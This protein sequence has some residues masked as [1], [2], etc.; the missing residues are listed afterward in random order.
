LYYSTENIE[1]NTLVDLNADGNVDELFTLTDEILQESIFTLNNTT[2]SNQDSDDDLEATIFDALGNELASGLEVA[3]FQ[4][5]L[6]YQIYGLYAP[7]YPGFDESDYGPRNLNA[8]QNDNLAAAI[9]MSFQD[10]LGGTYTPTQPGDK[11]GLVLIPDGGAQ[12]ILS[13]VEFSIIPPPVQDLGISLIKQVINPPI[14]TD[15]E[16]NPLYNVGDPVTFA[17]TVSNTGGADLENITLI[18]DNAT[19]EPSDDIELK[20]DGTQVLVS[21]GENDVTDSLPDGWSV[22]FSGDNGDGILNESEEWQFQITKPTQFEDSLEKVCET[23][24]CEF[25]VFDSFSGSD[26]EVT[27]ILEEVL[28]DP[29]T[30]DIDESGVRVNVEVSDPDLIGD[31]RGVFFDVADNNVMAIMDIIGNDVESYLIAAD[32]V[33]RV[34]KD[35]LMRGGGTEPFDVGVQIGTQGMSTDDIQSTSFDVV[36]LSIEDLELQRF[37]IRLTSVGED[38]GSREDSSKIIGYAPECGTTCTQVQTNLAG[39]TGLSTIGEEPV[40]DGFSDDGALA[41]L[42]TNSQTIM[43]MG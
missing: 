8:T 5:L 35:V 43:V 16:G 38:G 37:G 36:G 20:W 28:D 29:N 27:V 40:S 22:S 10:D 6:W 4:Y 42:D 26:I 24:P 9:A 21:I 32:D 33:D 3:D 41:D 2:W 19:P 7:D 12:W 25:V 18:D 11:V 39:V 13:T 15:P 23:E 14:A 34:E 1:E 31:L 17:Y 30:T